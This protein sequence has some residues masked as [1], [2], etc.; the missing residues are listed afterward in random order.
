MYR[1]IFLASAGAI[2]LS[3]SAALAAEPAPTPPP[4][5]PAFTWTGIYAGGQIGYAWTTGNN[6]WNGYDPYF[7]AVTGSPAYINTSLYNNPNGV[8]GGA[9]VGYNYQ[10][11]QLTWF[12]SSGIVL[13]IEG[14]VD[15]TSLS[16]T[17]VAAF[18]DGTLATVH[19]NSDVQGGIRGRL[20]IAW[21]RLLIYATGGVT[22][23]GFNTNVTIANAGL[24]NGGF[25][26]FASGS[27]V[28]TT[29]TAGTVGGGIQYA[30]TNNWSVR[31]EYRYTDWGTINQ[32]NFGAFAVPG[33]Y[34]N[35]QR[36]LYQNQ[37]Q[38]GFDYKFDLWAPPP[39]VAK[40]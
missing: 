26:L 40:Y 12:S 32:G 28:S 4:P 14:S 34:F 37:V 30:V 31:A 18:P 11:N 19:S 21:D 23:G 27:G 24:S 38:V 6:Y 1:K 29:R 7:F 17:G 22:W 8:I 36:T 35:G 9:N 3:G 33:V 16:N 10:F 25:P 39:V 5:A 15:G 13:G 20:G 2:V